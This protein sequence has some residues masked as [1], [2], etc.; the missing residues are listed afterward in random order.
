MS[1]PLDQPIATTKSTSLKDKFL[2]DSF[3]PIFLVNVLL[4]AAC[5]GNNY[6]FIIGIILV[7]FP[8]FILSIVLLQLLLLAFLKLSLW[9]TTFFQEEHNQRL[10]YWVDL[11]TFFR[12][13]FFVNLAITLSTLTYLLYYLWIANS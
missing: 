4:I 11:C 3:W 9:V 2:E 12:V 1:A 7:V 13:A 8:L 5:S 10:R 6:P